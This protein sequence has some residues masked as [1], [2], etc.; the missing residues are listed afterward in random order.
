MHTLALLHSP[1]AGSMTWRLVGAVLE[2][3][4][5]R[6]VVPSL[7]A[8][9]ADNAVSYQRLTRAAAAQID[10]RA[11]R[12]PFALVVHSGAGALAPA[13]VRQCEALCRAVLFV[14]ALLP[15]PGKSW[16][17]TIPDA[18]R[19]HLRSLAADGC[20]PPWD[21]WWPPHVMEAVLPD[22]SLRERFIAGLPQ[23]PL[24]YF[25][26]AASPD[27]LPSD[28]PCGYL[29]LSEAYRAEADAAEEM[30]WPVERREM[31]H[32]ATLTEPNRTAMDVVALLAKLAT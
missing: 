10:D 17:E 4:G 27:T 23:L 8:V 12:E 26:E 31:S 30:G 20:L 22:R 11:G 15:H 21:R 3:G 19:D 9:T 29:R 6:V 14:D 24:T 5:V 7:D 13:V 16:M 32:L 2:A 28:L 25:E 1:L 18:M